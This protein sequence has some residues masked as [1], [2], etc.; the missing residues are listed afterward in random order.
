MNVLSLEAAK[1][2]KAAGGP[3][4][5]HHRWYWWAEGTWLHD[6]HKPAEL[7]CPGAFGSGVWYE[8]TDADSKRHEAEW[9]ATPA[10]ITAL[11]W[12]EQE[13]GWRYM[14]A[15]REYA[16]CRTGSSSDGMLWFASAQP[17]W[18]DPVHAD[19]PDDLIIQICQ[20]IQETGQ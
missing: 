10:H 11:T 18:A 9:C 5:A 8:G 15:Y 6:L 17:Y 19:N 14:R 1:A 16:D 2:Y 20:R 4:D 3:Q 12:F 13:K 7:S